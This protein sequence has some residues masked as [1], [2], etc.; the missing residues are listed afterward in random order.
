M[1]YLGDSERLIPVIKQKNRGLLR[2]N[3]DTVYA[4][5]G[6]AFV[7]ET[8]WFT[9]NKKLIAAETIAYLMP[10]E[11]SIDIDTELDLKVCDHMLLDRLRCEDIE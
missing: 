7:A 5:N 10:K 2:Q 1:F 9:K 6:S 11:R 8:N 4:L 3:L